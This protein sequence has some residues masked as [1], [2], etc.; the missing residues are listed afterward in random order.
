MKFPPIPVIAGCK[1]LGLI[2]D[3]K[4]NFIYHQIRQEQMYKSYEFAESGSS[5]GLGCRLYNA[6]QV[7]QITHQVQVG[8]WVHCVRISGKI[9]LAFPGSRTNAACLGA[10]RTSPITSLHVEASELPVNLRREK[11]AL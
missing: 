9:L 11:L 4:L 6:H 8:L 10:F 5:L 3:R 1:F 7:V 2:F